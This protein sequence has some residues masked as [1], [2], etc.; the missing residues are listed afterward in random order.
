MRQMEQLHWQLQQPQQPG[1]VPQAQ[2]DSAALA[3]WALFQLSWPMWQE[4]PPAAV[5]A[6]G[7]YDLL[8]CSPNFL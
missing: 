3:S 8:L 5:P 7:T 2:K 6:A 1:L 4:L